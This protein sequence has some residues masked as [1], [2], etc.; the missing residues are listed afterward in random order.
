MWRVLQNFPPG[1]PVLAGLTDRTWG[2]HSRW[3][4]DGKRF[5]VECEVSPGVVKIPSWKLH[6]SFDFE[7]RDSAMGLVQR[8]MED[9]EH[10]TY[11]WIPRLA[12][13]ANKTSSGAPSSRQLK[14]FKVAGKA[15]PQSQEVKAFT[16]KLDKL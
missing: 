12:V 15:K 4:M 11:H 14:K 2:D 1:R 8:L 16:S 7:V 3:I 6:F 10:R 9:Q 13:Q 5:T